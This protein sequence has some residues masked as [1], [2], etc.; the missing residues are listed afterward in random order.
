MSFGENI[1]AAR[2]AAGLSQEA[3]GSILAVV[4]QTVSKWERNESLPD[5]ALLPKLAETLNV[6]IDGLFDRTLSDRETKE[7]VARCLH[8]KTADERTDFLLCLHRL[9]ME[10][11][12]GMTDGAIS[13]PDV[14]AERRYGLLGEKKISFYRSAG[15]CPAAFILSEPERGWASLFENPEKNG[16]LWTALGD[17]NAVR[18]ARYILSGPDRGFAER[19]ALKTL[20]KLENPEKTI[21]L[22]ESLGLLRFD[23]RVLDGRETE[24]AVFAPDPKVMIFLSL[25]E[26]LLFGENAAPEMYVTGGGW[27]MRLPMDEERV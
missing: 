22:L 13:Y 2:L 20:L 23:R 21:P 18:A 27:G 3:L 16:A 7:A 19:P 4:S 8:L 11:N 6:S 15:G 1:R 14:P 26:Q 12:L 25:A 10:M 5:A 9:V 17:P 24:V